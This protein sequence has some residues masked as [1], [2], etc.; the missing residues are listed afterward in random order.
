MSKQTILTTQ[1]FHWID[2]VN[3]T[4]G[5]LTVLAEKHGIPKSSIQDCLDS[6]HLPKYERFGEIHFAILRV[7]DE[8][9]AHD[10]DTVQELTRKIALFYNESF[11]LTVHRKEM[12][13]L[14]A[15]KE[16]S[17]TLPSTDNLISGILQDLISG[18]LQTYS[19]PI[20]EAHNKLEQLEIDVFEAKGARPFQIEEGYYLKRKA[21][22]FKRMLRASIDLLPKMTTGFKIQSGTPE[23]QNLKEIADHYFFF[24]DELMEN[25]NSLLN[26]Y[27]SLASQKTNEASHRTNEVMRLLTIFSMFLLPLNLVTGIYGMNFEY[28]PELKWMH[29]YPMAI[30]IMLL[31]STAIFFWFKKK[32]WLK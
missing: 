27:L 14:S 10:A 8:S 16:K 32:G 22:V 30:G 4:E 13:F 11:L 12:P 17:A 1:D 3:P 23:F 6:R 20:E 18:A 15:L 9:S 5:E 19:V 25:T 31:I 24:A 2:C 26:L 28:M 7:Y 21:S 29:G